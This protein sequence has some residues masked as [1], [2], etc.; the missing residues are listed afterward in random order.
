MT[1]LRTPRP[2]RGGDTEGEKK[3]NCKKIN[4]TPS[5][6]AFRKDERNVKINIVCLCVNWNIVLSQ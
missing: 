5:N 1:Q 2:P 3:F 4:I 6:K